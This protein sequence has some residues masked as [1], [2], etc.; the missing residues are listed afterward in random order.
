VPSLI[1]FTARLRSNFLPWWLSSAR[2]RA[3]PIT[4]RAEMSGD[5]T[6]KPYRSSSSRQA[7]AS[8]VRANR[9]L[10]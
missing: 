5:S 6:G 7:S 2:I 3:M 4:A 9:A 8:R 10:S 1:S